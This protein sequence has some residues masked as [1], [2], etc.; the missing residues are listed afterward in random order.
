M[1]K[2]YN[3]ENIRNT[4]IIGHIGCGKTLLNDAMLFASG[5]IEKRG[6]IERGSTVSDYTEEEIAHK[7]SIHASV[8]FLEYGEKKINVI[9]TPGAGDFLGE[10]NPA[11]RVAESAIVV[12]DAEFGIQIETEKKWYLANEYHRPRI[13]FVNKI[14]KDAIDFNSLIEKIENNFT[15]PPPSICTA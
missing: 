10:I 15:E 1:G 13:I 11:L 7:M 9:D 4:V 8:S 5:A 6:E 14:D 12:I 2:I 3:P